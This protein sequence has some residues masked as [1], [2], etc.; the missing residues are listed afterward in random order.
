MEAS[1]LALVEPLLNPLWVA[2]VIKE[3]PTAATV[4]GGLLILA[5]LG[6]RYALLGAG[7]RTGAQAAE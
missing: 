6:V 2:L 3:R 4:A 5:G 7:A 1:L